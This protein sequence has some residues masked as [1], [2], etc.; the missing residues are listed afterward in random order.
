MMDAFWF[1]LMKSAAE[2]AMG[3]AIF[4]FVL[5]A[6]IVYEG[7]KGFHTWYKRRLED[8]RCPEHDWLNQTGGYGGRGYSRCKK[9][10]VRREGWW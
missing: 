7:W 4:I 3:A 10:E 8:K 6:V 9:C 2:M 1:W 5:C